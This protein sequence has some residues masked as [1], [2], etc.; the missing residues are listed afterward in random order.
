MLVVTAV[1]IALAIL[2]RRAQPPRPSRVGAPA[3]VR[4]APRAGVVLVHG[5]CGFDSLGIGPLRVHYFRQVARRLGAAGIDAVAPRLPALGGVPA[6][7]EALARALDALPH[8]RLVVVAHSMGGLDARW[9]IAHGMAPRI[10][11]LIT[12]G[13]PHRGTPI[14]DLLARGAVERARLLLGRVGLP[15]EAVDWLTTTR[16][17][18]FDEIAPLPR[19][20]HCASIVAATSNRARVHPLLRAAHAYLLDVAGPN[21]G[22][23]PASSQRWGTVL[24]EHDLDH[25]AQVGWSGGHDCAQMLLRVLRTEHAGILEKR[26]ALLESGREA[27]HPAVRATTAA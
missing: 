7:A 21:D 23:V 19:G 9:A 6:R 5:I 12:I 13:T 8:D 17:A 24:A 3:I 27:R 18:V 11:T 20:V 1:L 26:P 16:L 14:A 2:Q 10:S 4:R 22:L 15:S 25:W